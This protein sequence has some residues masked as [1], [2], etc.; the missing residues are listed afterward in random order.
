MSSES[1]DLRLT[2]NTNTATDPALSTYLAKNQ[3]ALSRPS[4]S[5]PSTS[6]ARN[7]SSNAVARAS[8]PRIVLGP[9]VLDRLPTELGRL[10]LSAPLIVSSPSRSDLTSRIHALIPDCDTRVLDPSIIEQFPARNMDDGAIGAISGRDCV[11]SVGGGSA[12]ALARIIGWGKAIPHICIPTT[13][14]GSEFMMRP[15]TSKTKARD[16]RRRG[17]RPSND[18]KAT[19]SQPVLIIYDEDLT[20]S[21][22]RTIFTPSPFNTNGNAHSGEARHRTKDHTPWGYLNLPGI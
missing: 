20:V 12:V 9:G 18:S 21:T 15:P 7:F 14:S 13:Y 5:P 1:P 8:S 10:D 22:T 4:T 11:I 16:R 17:R 19:S 3:R 6:G 2:S